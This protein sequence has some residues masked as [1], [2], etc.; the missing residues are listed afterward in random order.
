SWQRICFVGADGVW[1]KLAYWVWYGFR[2]SIV[3]VSPVKLQRAVPARPFFVVTTMIPFDAF[4]PYSVAADGPLTISMSSI[5]S[6]LRLLSSDTDVWPAVTV[7]PEL[8]RTPSTTQMGAL[9][10]LIDEMPRMRIAGDPPT[11][12]P[13][14]TMTPGVFATR[15]SETDVTSVCSTF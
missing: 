2:S 13:G 14:R 1:P 10:R 7:L 4:V 9:V 11:T 12:E 8:K 6:G 3:R 15:R 5:S